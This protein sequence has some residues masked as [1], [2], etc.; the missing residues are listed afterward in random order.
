MSIETNFVPYQI[1]LD[2]KLLGFDEPCFTYYGNISACLFG[3]K[4]DIKFHTNTLLDIR[5]G[6]NVVSSA[7]L[8]QQA[9]KFFRDKHNLR[10]SIMDFI[11]DETGIEW[12]Y[13]IALIGTDLD[14]NGH[15]KPL[16]DYSTDD[17]SRKFKTYEEAELACLINLIQL[18]T[19][20]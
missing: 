2:M 18:V 8:Y 17:E 10:A 12:D 13:E 19:E 7:P 14:E 6:E 20:F 4:G 16:I 3:L 5:H 11:D 1:A 9:F 15:Y